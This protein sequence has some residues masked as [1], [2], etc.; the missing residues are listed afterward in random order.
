MRDVAI[1]GMTPSKFESSPQIN[2]GKQ[3]DDLVFG[4]VPGL[5]SESQNEIESRD[6]IV[7]R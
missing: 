5:S 2:G 7:A 4:S 1:T 6:S 3:I